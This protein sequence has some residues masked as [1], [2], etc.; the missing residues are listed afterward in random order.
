MDGNNAENC[1]AVKMFGGFEIVYKGVS[2]EGL[3]RRK[4]DR[5]FAYLALHPMQWVEKRLLERMFWG[6]ADVYDTNQNLR[7]SLAYLRKSLGTAAV[8]LESR[9]G[10]LRLRIAREQVDVLRLELALSQGA[11]PGAALAP[12]H[13]GEELLAGW[14]DDWI[15]PI[16]E[17]FSQICRLAREPSGSS[18]DRVSERANPSVAETVGGTV[19][20]DSPFYIERAV[21]K[22]LRDA[23]SRRE[24]IALIKG[25]RQ[26]GKS[27]LLARGMAFARET[28]SLVLHTDI[29]QFAT[30]DLGDSQMF[31]LRLTGRLADQADAEFEPAADW[32]PFLGAG[33]NLESFLRRRILSRGAA[34]VWAL[35]GVDR[36]F[37]TNYFEEF[38][39]LLRGFH[40]KHAAQQHLGWD[41]LTVII[42]T[43]TEAHLYVRDLNQSP[44]NVGARLAV[45][46]FT[47]EERGLL[48]DRLGGSPS[49]AADWN[50][51]QDLLG[52][53]PYL[54]ARGLSEMRADA[55]SV[56]EFTERALNT[57]GPFHDHLVRMLRLIAAD[58]ELANAM[59][60]ILRGDPCAEAAFFR[61]RSSGVVS[62]E[63][64]ADG[65]PRCSLYGRFLEGR[66]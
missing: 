61:L 45:G 49:R 17:R 18:S 33:A 52:G 10:A 63:N 13:D 14:R 51:L 65:R 64:P 35:D 60:S 15:I 3:H 7:Q 4:A 34:V 1:L 16:R 57:H 50:E 28:A 25:P 47:A 40:T 48:R 8:A 11:A 19:P 29:E 38:F 66:L 22:Q 23:I 6:S 12:F 56:A 32:K 24:S 36:L 55:L 26:T 46:D 53:H 42:A 27:S 58:T 41:R 54:L 62:G 5:F 31:F 21:D 20:S 9:K 39:A 2:L 30:D 44:F 59:R 43:A 37:S